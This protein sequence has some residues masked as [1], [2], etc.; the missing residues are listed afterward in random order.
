M[1]KDKELILV[2]VIVPIFNAEKYLDKCI[3]SIINQTYKNIEIILINDGSTDSSLNKCNKWANEDS[4]IK[5]IDKIN[6]GVSITRNIGIEMANGKYLTFVDAD[7]ILK[8]SF[9]LEAIEIASEESFDIIAGGIENSI[10][11]KFSPIET[12]IFTHQNKEKLI[13]A[14][15]SGEEEKYFPY[16]TRG[17][18]AYSFG[19]LYKSGFIKK[20][21]YPESIGYREDLIFN[22]QAFVASSS[23]FYTNNIWY[24]YILN[25]DSV[26]F[27]YRENYSNEAKIFVSNLNDIINS[28]NIK[29]E[30]ELN[31]CIMKTYISWLKFCIINNNSPMKFTEKIK[32]IQNS[33]KDKKLQRTIRELKFKNINITYRVMAIAYRMKLSLINYLMCKIN[34]RK[35]ERKYEK[36]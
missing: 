1:P 15:V 35:N 19:R 5:V 4:R 25:K 33:L 17:G 13:R 8:N 16:Y 9:I 26:C 12:I 27:K 14:L 21:K 28:T 30:D 22:L 7:D 6:E 20:I 24:E 10:G 32:K 18:C 23:I 29:L 36:I 3:H 34:N 2:S 31:I 11:E